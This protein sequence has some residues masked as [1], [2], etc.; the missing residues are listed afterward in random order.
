MQAPIL[1]KQGPLLQYDKHNM[2]VYRIAIDRSKAK[3]T[4][5][6]RNNQLL[7]GLETT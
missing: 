1:G 3:S 2:H 4:F 7:T 6:L 5:H